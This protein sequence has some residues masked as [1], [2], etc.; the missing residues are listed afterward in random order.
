LHGTIKLPFLKKSPECLTKLLT[1]IDRQSRH[2]QKNLKPY[3]IE[4]LMTSLGGK[5][6]RS[7]QKEK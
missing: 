3:G 2:F 6:D 1:G 7:V 4:F 5:V